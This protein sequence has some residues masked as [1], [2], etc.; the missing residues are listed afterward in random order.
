MKKLIIAIVLIVLIGGGWWYYKHKHSDEVQ[1]Q[2]VPVLRGTITQSVTATGTCSPVVSVQVG[3]QVSGNIQKLYADYNTP[4]KSGQIVAQLD[5]SIFQ[6]MVHQAEGD[7]QSAKAALELAQT[8]ARRKEELVKQHAAP[9]ADLDSAMA[10]LHQAE[11]A[12]QIKQANLENSKVNLDHCTIYAPIDGIVISR[13]VDV[14]QTVAAS[15][16]APVLFTIAND[17]H[18][19][20]I[21]ASVAEAD[22]GNV[23]PGQG[24]DFTVDAFPYETFHGK[25]MQVRNAPTTVQN[26][27]TYDCVIEVNNEELK[28]KPGMTANVSIIIA[29]RENALKLPNAALRFRPPDA[30]ES[31]AAATASAGQPGGA[32]AGGRPPGGGRGSGGG[33]RSGGGG[34]PVMRERAQRGDS[35]RTI[36]ILPEGETKPKPVQVKLGISDGIHTEVLEGLKEN[37]PVVTGVAIM[38]AS[39]EPAANPFGGMRRRF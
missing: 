30:Q 7:L 29:K 25:V 17:L 2:T 1:Y 20:Q 10:T 23:E 19:M 5:P 4:V 16:N 12:V 22:V 37:D 26:V 9:Q 33:G 15:M 32:G 24:V 21:D 11:A 38:D 27:V 35:A 14:G 28:L 13:A 36:Y 31:P 6:A 18:N 34:N 3:S 8:T 39:S